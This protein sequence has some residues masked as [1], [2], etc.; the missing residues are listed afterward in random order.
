MTANDLCRS[1]ARLASAI[2]EN[3]L[4]ALRPVLVRIKDYAGFAIV[5][6]LPVEVFR[7]C[8]E[9]YNG[10]LLRLGELMPDVKVHFRPLPHCSSPGRLRMSTRSLL[11]F[12][13]DTE[14]Y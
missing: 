2:P 7:P 6:G 5:T 10:V 1:Q 4:D 11:W 13:G 14:N 12:V 8:I 9:L 3:E